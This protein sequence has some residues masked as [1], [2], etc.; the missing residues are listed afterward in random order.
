MSR[1]GPRRIG[2][3]LCPGHRRL[4]DRR[5]G[6]RGGR[7]GGFADPT[8]GSLRGAGAGADADRGAVRVGGCGPR[9]RHPVK[10]HRQHRL[11]PRDAAELPAGRRTV[12]PAR[13]G[14]VVH[15]DARKRS[16]SRVRAGL[17]RRGTEL[18]RHQHAA[19]AHDRAR[20]D[21]PRRGFRDLRIPG[22]GRRR[23][24]RH[25][26]GL[27]GARACRRL[28]GRGEPRLRPRL[29]VG[30][31]DIERPHRPLRVMVRAGRELPHRVRLDDP[32]RHRPQ[33]RRGN[34][35]G[36]IRLGTRLSG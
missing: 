13:R 26:Q 4:S 6:D 34:R 14:P 19:R 29:R 8:A 3:G 18:L 28:P 15:A 36:F 9:R 21:S 10:P 23:Q 16:P 1:R 32:P 2:A 27:H 30:V 17:Q 24:H 33:R 35:G 5:P 7:G 11:L 25:A 20:R 22:G 12:Q 31:R